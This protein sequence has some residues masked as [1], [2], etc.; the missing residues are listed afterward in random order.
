MPSKTRCGRPRQRLGLPVGPL[1]QGVAVRMELPLAFSSRAKRFLYLRQGTMQIWMKLR[2]RLLK[3]TCNRRQRIV[4]FILSYIISHSF[5][6]HSNFLLSYI[7]LPPR[8]T[9]TESKSTLYYLLIT[10]SF[11]CSLYYL[12]QVVVIAVGFTTSTET[13]IIYNTGHY[14][15]SIIQ[16]L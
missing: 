5:P 4:V 9:P 10:L 7:Y 14:Y 3:Y 8:T 1:L 16:S 12:Q 15:S 2:T 6:V 13:Y 11:Y